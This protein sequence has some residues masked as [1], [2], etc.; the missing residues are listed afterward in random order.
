M[1]CNHVLIERL[2]RDKTIL[3]WYLRNASQDLRKVRVRQILYLWAIETHAEELHDPVLQLL[4]FD[5]HYLYVLQFGAQLAKA[6]PYGIDIMDLAERKDFAKKLRGI[7]WRPRTTRHKFPAARDLLHQYHETQEKLR[8]PPPPPKL[9][10]RPWFDGYGVSGYMAFADG[11]I[12]AHV[13][14]ARI[15]WYALP[16]EFSQAYVDCG[17]L[18]G[19]PPTADA[20]TID[21]LVWNIME[22]VDY[23]TNQDY[24]SAARLVLACQYSSGEEDPKEVVRKKL[25]A[26]KK[27]QGNI[28]LHV[29][30][31]HR[32]WELLRSEFGKSHAG[33]L[34]LSRNASLLGLYDCDVM[35]LL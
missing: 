29:F 35:A 7:F 30:C 28:P 11:D 15:G 1:G 8:N 9:R 33:S 21:K 10:D 25:D 2:Q 23:I 20:P 4:K 6:V 12:E 3:E 5:I 31:D 27:K 18:H 17:K 14:A 22:L 34:A 26:A 16:L 13:S 19:P 32:N 24:A